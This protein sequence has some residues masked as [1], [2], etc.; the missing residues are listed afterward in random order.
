MKGPAGSPPAPGPKAGPDMFLY[1][2]GSFSWAV[3]LGGLLA[4]GLVTAGTVLIFR[5]VGRWENRRF[6]QGREKSYDKL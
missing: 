3:A 6:R 5:T 1:P 2:A 4:L